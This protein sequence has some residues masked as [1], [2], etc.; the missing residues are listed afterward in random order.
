M[1]HNYA[2]S[3]RDEMQCEVDYL[4]AHSVYG[5]QEIALMPDAHLGKAHASVGFVSTYSDKIIPGTVG[6]DIACRV[7]AFKIDGD[8]DYETLDKAIHERVPAGSNIRAQEA[9]DSKV[10][11]Y[12][13]LR[14]WNAINDGEDRYRKSMGTL[15]SGNHFISVEGNDD[16]NWL[17]IHTGSRNLGLR[18]A[19]YY[20][21]LAI[22]RRDADK[23]Y[24][25]DDYDRVIDCLRQSGN[26]CD[27]GDMLVKRN[28]QLSEL[29]E[30]DLAYI[31]GDIMRDYLHDIDMIA[32]WS[33]L[34]HKVIAYEIA[35]YCG[36]SYKNSVSSIHNYVDTTNS[37]IRKGAI[38][39]YRGQYGI[40]PL[41]MRDGSIIVLGKGNGDW[42][43]S[44]PHGAGRILS[45]SEARRELDMEDYRE[46]MDGIYTTSVS[47]ST[48]DE[49]P[50]AYKPA[51][52]I[53]Q[54]IGANAEIV[55][56]LYPK[57]NFKAS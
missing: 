56:R 33:F 41:N 12:D 1:I 45:R 50:A 20:Q 25:M 19:N 8:V 55:E 34:N 5:G 30:D 10:F 57:Y 23:R 11:R 4:T 9:N 46:S 16:G 26:V 44:L 6:V 54:A 32:R 27:I 2:V 39:A 36:F 15:G 38:A 42:L 3:N 40:I 51:E 28:R 53:E 49:A 17:M 24:I 47:K 14:C 52:E 43:Y 13:S 37:I 21:Q 7:S 31:D 22:E 18:V 48:I 35:D 29:P